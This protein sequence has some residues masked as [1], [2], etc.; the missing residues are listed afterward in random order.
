MRPPVD[1]LP[2]WM[3]ASNTANGFFDATAI[4]SARWAVSSAPD[5]FTNS[6]STLR[7]QVS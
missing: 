2:P 3:A 7:P 1:W 5:P 6:Y 4:A